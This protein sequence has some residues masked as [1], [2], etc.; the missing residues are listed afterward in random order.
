MPMLV[1]VFIVSV[2]WL[3]N[4]RQHRYWW[5]MPRD[6]HT[7]VWGICSQRVSWLTWCDDVIT[8]RSAGDDTIVSAP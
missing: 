6:V 2:L 4:P 3:C 5:R 1:A 7:P 8:P